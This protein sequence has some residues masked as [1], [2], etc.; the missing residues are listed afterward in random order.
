[1]EFYKFIICGEDKRTLAGMKNM[2][3]SS[4]HLFLGYSQETTN[5]IRHIRKVS[6]D[7]VILEVNRSFADLRHIIEIIDEELLSAVILVVDVSNDEISEFLHK[8][9]IVTFT[10]K[11]VM[12][13]AFL[14]IVDVS[15]LNYHRII[16]Y[17]Q[18]IRQLNES[19]ESRKV[20][21]KAK[22]ILVKCDGL[23]ENEAFEII[24]KKSRDNR[25]PMREIAEA[26][27]MVR[28]ND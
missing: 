4:G 10:A 20:V 14:Q 28:G 1:M 25:M 15:M 5:V 19:L 11:P 26:I 23:S 9:R 13:E 17:E 2:L 27:L 18:K 7:L 8:S 16:E 6:P 3:C 24:R 12:E 21:E 22:W